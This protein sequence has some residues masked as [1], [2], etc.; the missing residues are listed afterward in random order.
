MQNVKHV[1]HVGLILSVVI[2]LFSGVCSANEM[3]V[4]GIFLG[5]P[6][7]EA[8]KIL[9]NIS[10]SSIKYGL[11][12]SYKA[13][14]NTI[15]NTL[16]IGSKDF[17]YI[18]GGMGVEAFLGFD[19]HSYNPQFPKVNYMYFATNFA[20]KTFEVNSLDSRGFAQ[21]V[22]N[23]YGLG[24]MEVTSLK[25]GGTVHNGWRTNNPN[26]YSVVIFYEFWVNN[27]L[28]DNQKELHIFAT[29]K[30]SFQ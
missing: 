12:G 13:Y 27:E 11:G 14:I 8:C 19:S 30:A 3:N 6:K 18:L 4:K 24:D 28:Y 26:G 21:A 29:K 15:A 17:C 20:N 7:A 16:G 9:A 2:F 22:I 10:S 5:Q 25:L 23:N 1:I